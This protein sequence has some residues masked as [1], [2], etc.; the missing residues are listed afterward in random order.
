MGVAIIL[1]LC[2]ASHYRRQLN[3][4]AVSDMNMRIYVLTTA[5]YTV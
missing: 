5:A 2:K 1:A 3:V 4:A